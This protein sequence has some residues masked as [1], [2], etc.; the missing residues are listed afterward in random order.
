MT[1][2]PIDTAAALTC[3]IGTLIDT[4]MLVQANS[5]GG[6]SFVVRR[7]L[8]QT[9]AHVQQLVIDPEGEFATLRE[10]FDYVHA[11]AVD[12][13]AI[14]NPRSAAL[15][16][17]KLLELR[18]SAILD[19][20]ELQAHDRIRFVRLFLEALIN[21]PK[22][23]WHPVLVVVDEAHVFCPQAGQ[24]ESAAAVIDLA[25]RGRKRGFCAVLAT[26][27]I[28]KLHKDA[29][30]ELNNKLI[31]RTSL[32]VDLARASDELGFTKARWPELKQ[33]PAGQ[34]F[35]AGPA[36]SVPGVT[37]VQVGGVQT[38][39]PK[40]GERIAFAA[41]PPTAA[42]RALLPQLSDLPAEAE[43]RER[44]SEEL[45]AEVRRLEGELE[46]LAAH[47][48]VV[49]VASR[50]RIEELEDLLK[51]ASMTGSVLEELG[52]IR[53]EMQSTTA[54]LSDRI[55]ACREALHSERTE[56]RAAVGLP[57]TDAAERAAIGIG[58]AKAES[59]FERHLR[60]ATDE[61]GGDP[62]EEQR[63]VARQ[64]A[65]AN[66][67][68]LTTPSPGLRKGAR[69][70]LVA[71]VAMDR[72]LT[73]AQVATLSGLSPQSGTFSTYISD[74]R[75]AGLVADEGNALVATSPGKS[76]IGRSAPLRHADLRALWGSKLRAGAKRMLDTLSES[77]PRG[78]SRDEL[79]RRVEISVESGTFS[80][81]LSDL[82]T[83]GLAERRGREV[84]ASSSL[85]LAGRR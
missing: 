19:L 28:Q 75:T 20:Y 64:I 41:P 34:F 63:V 8:E 76:L 33:L 37:L 2:F 57:S 46:D 43:E 85:F 62:V 78:M 60:E 44:T 14:A 12:G 5:G 32:D 69:A 26:Q 16:A 7:I 70:M 50:A 25:S 35:A 74:L 56:L 13:D 11:A 18:A 21:A 49:D 53:E 54:K 79:A 61:A 39:H 58:P 51:R 9:H 1:S 3:D 80:T 22:K 47:A 45:R 68:K 40:A 4:R 72:P 30:A 82:V 65:R 31:G 59:A 42:I 24:A 36:F 15:L 38:T 73:R 10:R 17:E 71:L 27:R 67:P 23:L 66:S 77:Y 83:N 81:Y 55:S 84:V 29:A 52:R 6:K 48:P